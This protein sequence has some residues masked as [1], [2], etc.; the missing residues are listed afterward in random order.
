[1]AAMTYTWR[2]HCRAHRATLRWAR[3]QRW[4][5]WLPALWVAPM[6]LATSAMAE[7]TVRQ[8]ED[9]SWHLLQRQYDGLIRSVQHGFTKHEC[10]FAVARA[11]GE[12]ATDEER[13]VAAKVKAEREAA[14]RVQEAKD[15]ADRA[16]WEGEHPGCNFLYHATDDAKGCPNE[17]PGGNYFI[18]SS[19]GYATWPSHPSTDISSA[20]C[21][22]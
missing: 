19:A 18:G 4:K 21:F 15:K 2:D 22:Q 14:A 16:K 17:R 3:W 9:R 5:H 8:P 6:I 12:P 13:A 1:M 10:E 7:P 20:E 11:R